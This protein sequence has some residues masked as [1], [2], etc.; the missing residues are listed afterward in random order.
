MTIKKYFYIPMLSIMISVSPSNAQVKSGRHPAP[1]IR[2]NFPLSLTTQQVNSMS[3]LVA[4]RKDVRLYILSY[5]AN[6]VEVQIFSSNKAILDTLPHEIHTD[7]HFTIF[8]QSITH[9]H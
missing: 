1:L 5:N 4:G 7:G 8:G 3:K 6:F 9:G 2:T